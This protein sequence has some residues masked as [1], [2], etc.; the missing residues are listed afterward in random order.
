M[1]TPRRPSPSSSR[2]QMADIAVDPDL[3][4]AIAARLD[5]REP[6]KE[7]LES[8]AF[9]IH[10]HYGIEENP[11]PFE[12]VVDVA[13]GVGKTYVLAASVE[14]LA[15]SGVRNFAVI[16]PG[17]TILEKTVANFSP[18]HAKSL[19]PGMETRPVVITS[20][21]FAT[22]TMRAAM[23]DEDQIKLYVFT[24][25]A[26]TKPQTEVGRRTHKFQEGLGKAFYEH[27][28]S[29]ED[30][31][32]FADEHHV[33]YGAAFSKAVRGLEPYALIGLTATP[34]K[35]TPKEQIIYRYPLAA[36][37]ADAIVKTPVIV[38][39]KDDRTDPE[40]KLGD[41]IRLLELKRRV[42]E[43][44]AEETGA[45]PLNPVMLVVAQTIEDAD[46]YAELIREDSFFGGAYADS[47][48]VVHS[49]APDE[50]LKELEKVEDTTSPVRII[51]SVGMLKEGWDVKNVY[52]IASMR[53]SVSEML[54]E[55]TLGRGLRLPFGAYTGMEILDTLEVLA[56]ERYEDLLKKA[57]VI[58][59]AFIDV[60]TRAV[61]R[62]DAEGRQVA[63]VEETRVETPVGGTDGTEPQGPDPDRPGALVSSVE[64][65]SAAVEREAAA[66]QTELAPRSD[67]PALEIP[68]L[69]M[70][71]LESPFSLSDIVD[72][73]PFRKAGQSLAADPIEELRRTTVSARIIE[74][75][76]GLRQTELVTAPAVDRIESPASLLPM[77]D[78]VQQLLDRI[79]SS[80]MVPA[81]KT[82]RAAAGPIVDAFLE[83]LGGKAQ[84]LLSGYLD[85]AA[86][87]LISLIAEQ[88]RR[89]AGKPRFDEVTEIVPFNPVRT[90]RSLVSS[91]RAGAFK[92]GAAYKGW[93]KSMYAQVWF[94]SSTERN[95]ANILDEANEVEFW[96]RLHRGD[97][98]ILWSSGNGWY[99]PDFIVVETDGSHW[100]VEV[101]MDKEVQTTTVQ[102]KREAAQRWANYVS[103]DAKVGK[104]WAY[105]LVSETDVRTARGSWPS[106]KEL[107]KEMT[108]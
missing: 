20:E 67:L 22:P 56:H 85:R 84:E 36:A 88:Q 15:A 52:V 17:R 57:G 39:R 38:G 18:G 60:R 23:E 21:N 43:R 30:L 65:R 55:Q 7:A 1:E 69:V 107:G 93:K 94:D 2:R 44:Y 62:L 80:P 61:M 51:I 103:A 42:T 12:A 81:R 19:L 47:V 34:H 105:L 50:A 90:A 72:L 10:Q 53:S 79:L 77:E 13:T 6:N 70:R 16:T 26:L 45:E 64:T 82:E 76:D 31:V 92:R 32:V 28:V 101:K 46:H 59:E 9:E 66:L 33:Y 54:T 41:G 14:F 75:A 49:D 100:V 8:I 74:G 89:F 97:L 29:C 99:N 63:T 86:G 68:R 83:G 58:N 24:V 95:V 37:I 108:R 102:E 91:D 104:K 40:T 96:V 106:L 4:E 11:P 3:I 5:L 48:L 73:D 27:L 71:N 98:P 78:A 25:Q 87:R 35:R